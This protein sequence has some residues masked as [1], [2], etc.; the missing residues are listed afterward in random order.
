MAGS[1]EVIRGCMFSG[2]TERL[3]RTLE[4]FRSA[5]QEY[6]AFKPKIDNRYS[7]SKIVSHN[8]ISIPAFSVESPR[9]ILENAD[10]VGIVA[11][12]EVQFF[13][14]KEIVG[15]VEMLVREGRRV[16]VAGLDT[17]YRGSPF[18][19]VGDLLA[20]ADRDTHL[21]SVCAVCGK[22]AT[23]TQLLVNKKP[24][25]TGE[26]VI[27]VGGGERF[28]IKKYEYQPRCRGCHTIG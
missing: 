24:A 17:D 21:T 5:G 7:D 18:G 10:Q 26:P 11:I 12:D 20:I 16:I 19:F 25:S 22:T 2:K 1:L 9:E 14:T 15:C 28:G 13:L 27:L 8:G 3:C 23:R 4:R 6:L